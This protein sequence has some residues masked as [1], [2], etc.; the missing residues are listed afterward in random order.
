MMNNTYL[1]QVKAPGESKS[2]WDCSKLAG[3]VSPEDGIRSIASG[4]CAMAKG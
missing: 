4:S 1:F 2:E 3:T